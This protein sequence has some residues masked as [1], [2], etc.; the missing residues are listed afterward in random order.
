MQPIPTRQSP[1]PT[2]AEPQAPQSQARACPAQES[3]PVG[4]WLRV[5]CPGFAHTLLLREDADITTT[6][7]HVSS[8]WDEEFDYTDSVQWQKR[9]LRCVP[10]LGPYAGE[11]Q[12]FEYDAHPEEVRWAGHTY[13]SERCGPGEPGRSRLLKSCL[14][15]L[16]REAGQVGQFRQA[17]PAQ[18]LNP[19]ARAALLPGAAAIAQGLGWRDAGLQQA[20]A[21]VQG[22]LAGHIHVEVEDLEGI[23]VEFP[24]PEGSSCAELYHATAAAFFQSGRP[25]ADF[26]LSLR[27]GSAL[28][29]TSPRVGMDQPSLRSAAEGNQL[30]GLRHSLKR[31]VQESASVSTW[32][33]SVPV[34]VHDL[35]GALLAELSLPVGAGAA[36]CKARLRK[37]L[38]RQEPDECMHLVHESGQWEDQLLGQLLDNA[39][40]AGMAR[41]TLVWASAF[42]YVAVPVASEARILAGRGVYRSP[43]ELPARE[44]GTS[45]VGFRVSHDS[46][47][48]SSA[49]AG[50]AK[51]QAFR[52]HRQQREPAQV[53]KLADALPNLDHDDAAA[54]GPGGSPSA[55]HVF[56]LGPEVVEM[57]VNVTSDENQVGGS[58]FNLVVPAQASSCVLRS[59]LA[60]RFCGSSMASVRLALFMAKFDAVAFKDLR[61]Y[62]REEPST[63]GF[64][65]SQ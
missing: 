40:N 63:K 47:A 45:R 55:L 20:A 31:V 14:L 3:K 59:F 49:C 27:D 53:R 58:F 46:H 15:L 60:Q 11:E 21:R 42:Q 64:T 61:C 50:A 18:P 39:D 36:D 34:V 44:P 10:A 17:Q 24:M 19:L 5:F 4:E 56:E 37:L 65:L 8:W 12:L 52:S 23:L 2:P 41:L 28:L 38:S 9:T 13:P 26:I 7:I 57:V 29:S 33:P 1:S 30:L 22:F 54:A 48:G 25:L 35:S 6:E 51:L 43:A 16:M 32:P 62:L